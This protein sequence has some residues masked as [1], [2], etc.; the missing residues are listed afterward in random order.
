MKS[1]SYENIMPC[2]PS[3]AH[4]LSLAT[5]SRTPSVNKV[6]VFLGIKLGVS[7]RLLTLRKNLYHHTKYYQTMRCYDTLE[8]LNQRFHCCEEMSKSCRAVLNQNCSLNLTGQCTEFILR[9]FSHTSTNPD[10]TAS[11][12]LDE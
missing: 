11:N 2:S 5:C 10:L 1:S 8:I 6:V 3:D 12:A 4:I 9:L 7:R